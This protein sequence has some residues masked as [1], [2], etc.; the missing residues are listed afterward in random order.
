MKK[1]IIFAFYFGK[2]PNYFNLW[3]NSVEYNNTI[4]FVL[5]TDNEMNCYIPK[6]MFYKQIT[7]EDMIKKIS[8]YFDFPVC[9]NKPYKIAE[10]RCGFGKIFQEYTIGYDFWGHC[11]IDVVFGDLRKFFSEATLQ[12]YDRINTLAHLILYKN[13]EKVNSLFMKDHNFA[14]YTYK[15]AYTKD[16]QCFYDEWGGVSAFAPYEGI[17]QQDLINYADLD[18]FKFQ[19]YLLNY[20]Q[21]YDHQI[22]EW[23]R[24]KLYLCCIKNNKVIKNELEYVHFQKRILEVE[25]NKKCNHFFIIPNRFIEAEELTVEL[26]KK[27]TDNLNVKYCNKMKRKLWKNALTI[28]RIREKLYRFYKKIK[29]DNTVV[30]FFSVDRKE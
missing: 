21:N 16:Y 6:N 9:I 19:F 30:P 18:P 1:I 20:H 11:D 15:E 2:L 26:I 22:L 24:G 12:K 10:Y 28:P 3:I 27:Y 29:Y 7:Y 4:D 25:I 14:C 8:S 5:F 17:L 13:D 23:D